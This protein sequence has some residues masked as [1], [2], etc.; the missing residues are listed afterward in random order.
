M[1]LL[2]IAVT[3]ALAAPAAAKK[4]AFAVVPQDGGLPPA[5]DLQL[6]KKGGVQ[7]VRLMA[8]WPTV[9]PTKG[10]RYDWTIL[11]GIVRETTNRGL[12]P[13]FFFYGTPD[14]AAAL[15]GRNCAPGTG[16]CSVYPPGSKKTRRAFAAFAAAAV[17]RYG[18]GGAFWEPS[19]ASRPSLA[20][21]PARDAAPPSLFGAQ[22]PCDP[23][24]LPGCTPIPAPPGPGTPPPPPPPPSPA[25]PPGA[26][27]CGCTKPHP[28][29]VWQVWNEQ[30]SPK[31]F[32]PKIDV[33]SY[34]KLLRTTHRAIAK[35]NRK[36]K[37]ILGGMWGPSSAGKVVLP[38]GAYLKRL[39]KIEGVERT[40]D[41]IGLHPYSKNVAGSLEQLQTA[42][43]VARRAG[44]RR[45]D[46][47]VTEIGWA[48]AGPNEDPYVKGL[49]GQARMLSKTLGKMKKN[50]AAY[51]LRAIYWYS[52][53]DRPGG[54][55][56]CTWCGYAGLRATDG[57]AKPAWKAFSRLAKR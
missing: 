21:A 30:N 24:P 5:S 43:R 52:W 26:P 33:R 12:K 46:T 37:L 22:I 15:D 2:A 34:A 44:D 4:P 9:Q 18:A 10:S 57:T 40:F 6:M 56:I 13:L 54:E 14:W 48:A 42:R 19:P 23:I 1:L 36:T 16:A 50:A 45:V 8:H 49:K 29:R 25:P 3:L 27:P 35:V 39:Y 11:D 31:Y 47:Y 51:R 7:G 55:K 17:K 20:S 38:I 28:I 32:A 41:A 53:R